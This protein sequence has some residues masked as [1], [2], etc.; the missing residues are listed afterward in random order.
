LQLR[1]LGADERTLH[2]Q[3]LGTV[4][5]R[6][7]DRLFSPLTLP[8]FVPTEA[9]FGEEL[10]LRGYA[11]NREAQTLTLLW[12]AV[13]P[14]SADYTAFVHLLHPDGVCCVWQEDRPPSTRPTSLW[15]TD[16]FVVTTHQLQLP[17]AL[18]LGSYPLEVGLYLPE[19]GQR[20]GVVGGADYFMLEPWGNEQ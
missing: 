9:I 7:S 2:L 20:L 18:P 1:L 4:N 14:P 5:V 8:D 16:E 15:L 17:P 19:N 3:P 13:K 6:P 12:Q 11:I 10:A